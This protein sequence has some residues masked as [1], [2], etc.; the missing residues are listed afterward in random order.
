MN[1]ILMDV[2]GGTTDIAVIHEG[3]VQGTKMFGIGG[4]AFTRSIER[5]LGIEFL[6][7]E[8]LKLNLDNS[9]IPQHKKQQIE[10]ALNKTLDVWVSGVELALSEF[11]NLDH[12]PNKI[13]LCG[14]GSSLELL[15]ERLHKTNW[16]KDLPFTRR[17]VIQHIRPE[18]VI[19]INDT[20]GKVSDH[21]LVTA[22]GLLR[23]GLDTLGQQDDR[24]TS[25]VREKID[26]M[27]KI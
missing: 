22:M 25:S 15:T 20:T 19:G 13:L 14:G 12:L 16:Y 21:T 5:A 23:V 18:Q 9:R 17:P 24:P 4:R 2:G 6:Q 3:G 7:A 1:A 10:T 8:Q 11:T 26:R 27:L